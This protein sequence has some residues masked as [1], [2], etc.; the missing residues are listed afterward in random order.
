MAQL[1]R[2]FRRLGLTQNN[3]YET[4]RVTA[5]SENHILNSESLMRYIRYVSKCLAFSKAL[6]DKAFSYNSKK[7]LYNLRNVGWY[8]RLSKDYERLTEM[9]EAAI[10]AVMTRIMLR[11]LTA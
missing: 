7:L 9:S 11:R 1:V 10:Y 8:R 3:I 6:Q 2:T 4:T 5:V